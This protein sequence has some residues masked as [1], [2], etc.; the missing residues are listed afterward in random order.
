MYVG[1][2]VHVVCSAIVQK[3]IRTYLRDQ[4][5]AA[6][7]LCTLLHCCKCFLSFSV[8][9]FYSISAIRKFKL[10]TYFRDY[11]PIRLIKT[12]DLPADTNYL[13]CVYPHGVLASG[14]VLNFATDANDFEK[15]YPGLQ[16]HLLTLS[17]NFNLP[18]SRETI[19]GLG[20]SRTCTWVPIVNATRF[21][22][23]SSSSS[24]S[25][26]AYSFSLSARLWQPDTDARSLFTP[27]FA[28]FASVLT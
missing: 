7:S 14:A 23:S 12:A 13:F 24:S 15:L 1:K 2:Y 20:K 26:C 27:I 19:L 9:Y 22:S 4:P 28:P 21:L 18:F 11:F 6:R 8:T 25:S 17:F 16:A 10:W 5:R 3:F